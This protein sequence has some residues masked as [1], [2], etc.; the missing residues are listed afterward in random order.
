MHI[1]RYRW[2][3]VFM[4]WFICFFNYADRQAISSIFPVLQKQYHI[5]KSELGLIGAV[6]GV[7]IG[8]IRSKFVV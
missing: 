1:S 5:T 4:L 6:G 2:I 7:I 8:L 3:V